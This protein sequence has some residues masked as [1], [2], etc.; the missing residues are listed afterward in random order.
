MSE[1]LVNGWL[2]ASVN[3]RV[4]AVRLVTILGIARTYEA[5]LTELCHDPGVEVR[6]MLQRPSGFPTPGSRHMLNALLFDSDARVQANAVEG[7]G[8]P[9]GRLGLA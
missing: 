1:T 7:A 5:R 3:E 4:R 6:S 8:S 9:G 2:G